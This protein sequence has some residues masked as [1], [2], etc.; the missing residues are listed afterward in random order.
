M[1]VKINRPITYMEVE[2]RLEQSF[3][4][5]TDYDIFQ[6]HDGKFVVHF[7]SEKYLKNNPEKDGRNK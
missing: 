7:F 5:D 2:K 4:N 6:K 3:N 1:N